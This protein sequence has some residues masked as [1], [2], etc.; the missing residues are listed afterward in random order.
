[1]GAAPAAILDANTEWPEANEEE[2]CIATSRDD[3]VMGHHT[4]WVICGPCQRHIKCAAGRALAE[5]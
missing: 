2:R 1:M 3:L 5:R 4:F